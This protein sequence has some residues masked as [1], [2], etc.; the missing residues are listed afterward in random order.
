VKAHTSETDPVQ[1]Y[2]MDPYVL[3]LA[4]RLSSTP[5]IYAYD[6]NTDAAYNGAMETLPPPRNQVV[7]AEIRAL[8]RTHTQA[9]LQALE[10]KPPKA[11]I[12]FDGAPLSSYPTALEDLQR[13]GRGELADVLVRDFAPAATFGAIHVWL[14]RR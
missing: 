5:F 8:G 11:W 6:L 4:K 3:F 1:T 12:L 2:G 10:T 9:M 14:P 13:S 7:A